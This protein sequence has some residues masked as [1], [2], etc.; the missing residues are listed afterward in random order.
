MIRPPSS[1]RIMGQ[2]FAVQVIRRGAP[3]ANG[4][5]GVR[6]NPRVVTYLLQR[7]S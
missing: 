3:L 5:T 2:R 6:T 1:F 4:A 7:L